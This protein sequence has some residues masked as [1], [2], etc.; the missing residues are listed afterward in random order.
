[1]LR[2]YLLG[3]VMVESETTLL[4]SAAFPGRQG[5]LA[6]AYLAERRRRVERD[7]LA[8]V[9]WP[10]EMPDA[11]DT[12]VSAIISK[13]RRALVPAGLH[14]DFGLES[15]YGSYELRLPPGTW[16]DL[17]EAVAALDRAEGAL[18]AG[19]GR[20][21][22]SGAA[23]ASAI[24]VRP[25]LTGD[26]GPWV[27]ATRHDLTEY[28]VRTYGALAGAWLAC[29]NPLAAVAASRL[30]VELA[31]YRESCHARLMEAH[32]AA[33]NRAEAVRVYHDLRRV[34]RDSLGISPAG[35]VESLYLR[36]LD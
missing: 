26:S 2:I 35:D 22:W 1:M 5:R 15:V 23:V 19:D 9:I 8:E 14:G 25:F 36:A 3:R 31:P 34:L 20:A 29:G 10:Q 6:F 18:S 4:G 16:V 11:W 13:L 33:G 7:E 27:E 17:R 32:M 24:F 12:A 30:A 28:R 21:A